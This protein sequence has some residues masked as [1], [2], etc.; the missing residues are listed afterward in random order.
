MKSAKLLTIKKKHSG[1]DSAGHVSIRHRGGEH[2]RFLR[3]IDWRRP[4][5]GISAT[6]TAIEYDPNRTVRIALLSYQNGSKSYILAPTGLNVGDIVINSPSASIKNGNRLPLQNI[7][8]GVPIHCLELF[9]GKG[10]QIVKSAGCAAYL[11]S[12]DGNK[13]IVKLPSTELRL[14]SATCQATIEIG[15]AHV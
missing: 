9:P 8:V 3:Q 6:V 1:R 2:K 11:Q 12:V 7:P 13:A 14:F 15:R 4:H 10:A 5:I